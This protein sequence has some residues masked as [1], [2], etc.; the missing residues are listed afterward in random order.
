MHQ[1]A[2]SKSSSFK[3]SM[4]ADKLPVPVQGS[5]NHPVLYVDM[6]H[7]DVKRLLEQ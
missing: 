1:L 3:I 7:A 5:Q 2:G 6:L 4:L